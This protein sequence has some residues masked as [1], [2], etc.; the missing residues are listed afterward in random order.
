IAWVLGGVYPYTDDDYA[1]KER[2]ERHTH[3]G[4]EVQI[5]LYEVDVDVLCWLR[6]WLGRKALFVG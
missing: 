5:S 4:L 2:F 3:G 6:A 1:R